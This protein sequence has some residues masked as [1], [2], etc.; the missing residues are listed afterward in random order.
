MGTMRKVQSAQMKYFS[1]S[2]L[3]V[4][5]TASLYSCESSHVTSKNE[6][7]PEGKVLIAEI[8]AQPLE[9]TLP[10]SES[11][12]AWA[13]ATHFISK[14]SSMKMQTASD[15][16][17]ST[18]NP[19]DVGDFGYEVTRMP[20][21]IRSS[22]FTSIQSVDVIQEVVTFNVTCMYRGDVFSDEATE[23]AHAAAYYIATGKEPLVYYKP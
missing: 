9:F 14:Y 5:I 10:K 8:M 11:D 15:F 19:L 16:L 12:E 13:R 22:D 7:S 2:I 21:T 20:H 3:S 4:C 23:N 1:S 6:L 18:Y 17:L